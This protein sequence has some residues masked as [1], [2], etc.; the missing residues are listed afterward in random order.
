MRSLH[1]ALESPLLQP[2]PLP[3]LEPT[4]LSPLDELFDVVVREM[5]AYPTTATTG[6]S[7]RLS[8]TPVPLRLRRT[9]VFLPSRATPAMRLIDWRCPLFVATIPGLPR[10]AFDRSGTASP[11]TR[12]FVAIGLAGSLLEGQGA[13]R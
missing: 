5:R 4:S 9:C 6:F 2:P 12:N 1:S 8:T 10:P 3:P 11:E 13:T 7:P